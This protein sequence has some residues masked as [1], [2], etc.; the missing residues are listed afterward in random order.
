MIRS[1]AAA[2]VDEASDALITASSAGFRDR[3]D[4]VVIFFS[5]E[6]P[7]NSE[8]SRFHASCAFTQPHGLANIVDRV[9]D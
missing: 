7:R 5:P 4:L 2:K 3:V 1:S 9:E 6:I 8:Y